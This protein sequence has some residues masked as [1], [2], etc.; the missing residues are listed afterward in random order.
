MAYQRGVTK[1]RPGGNTERQGTAA[2][3]PGGQVSGSVQLIPPA[4]SSYHQRIRTRRAR[5]N[6]LAVHEAAAG[7]RDDRVRRAFQLDGG[8]HRWHLADLLPVY[9]ANHCGA[10]TIPVTLSPAANSER[11][12]ARR[13]AHPNSR[14]LLSNTP[15]HPALCSGAVSECAQMGG[16]WPDLALAAVRGPAARERMADRRPGEAPRLPRSCQP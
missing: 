14:A 11:T 2:S 1:A 12:G 9:A 8:F 10:P 7:K 6:H 13:Y 5:A 4:F 15:S 3:G 16:R